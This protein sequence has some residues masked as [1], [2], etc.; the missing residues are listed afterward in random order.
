MHR[1]APARSLQ[2]TL[3]QTDTPSVMIRNDD[4][5]HRLKIPECPE[6][7]DDGG[8]DLPKL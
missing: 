2:G 6:L 1:D 5:N 4:G 8:L 7:G 3:E